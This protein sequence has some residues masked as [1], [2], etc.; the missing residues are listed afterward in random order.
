MANMNVT[1]SDLEGASKQLKN[2]QADIESRLA[3]L[4]GLIDNLVGSGYV[5]D[6]SSKA[7]DSSY[8]E[9]NDGVRKTV[10]GLDGMSQYLTLASNTLR[11]TD[12]QLA[13]GLGR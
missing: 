5:T 8:T 6:R 13:K 3:E 1:Y 7:F 12:E 4:K 2:G 10:E 11:D 9:F